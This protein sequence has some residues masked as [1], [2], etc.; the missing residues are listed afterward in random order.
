MGIYIYIRK[1]LFN[2]S[3]LFFINAS[4]TEEQHAARNL[5]KNLVLNNICKNY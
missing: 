2:N 4:K 3:N 5:L 1:I